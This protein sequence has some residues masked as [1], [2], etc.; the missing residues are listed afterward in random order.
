VTAQ[1]TLLAHHCTEAGL[2][3]KAIDYWLAAGRQAW[4]R[5]M[6]AE[7]AALLRRGLTL[8]TSL[9]ENRWRQERELNL[10]IALGQALMASQGW[11]TEQMS[12]A[13]ARAHQLA[14]TLNR[15]RELL[16]ALQAE[17]Q[18]QI[19]R[20]ELKRASELAA[21]LRA[22]GEVSNDVLARVLGY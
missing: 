20:A 14:V 21:E 13:Y 16:I 12:A 1:P 5:S 3:Q 9:D 22:Y 8:I 4:S 6:L 7:A 15:P 10:Q 19:S 2:S 11:G 18:H 17:F